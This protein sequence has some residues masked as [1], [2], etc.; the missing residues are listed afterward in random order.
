MAYDYDF[1][2]DVIIL[3]LSRDV[4][5]V[6][7]ENEVQ[8]AQLKV[9]FVVCIGILFEHELT[10]NHISRIEISYLVSNLRF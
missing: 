4:E 2:Y 8:A 5:V 7:C 6:I 10:K 9:V 3:I 1:F